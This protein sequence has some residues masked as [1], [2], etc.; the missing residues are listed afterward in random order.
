MCVGT[1]F[2]RSRPGHSHNMSP[3]LPC[4]F[5]WLLSFGVSLR[6]GLSAH[7]APALATRPVSAFIPGV[8]YRVDKNVHSTVNT[9]G[10]KKDRA[11]TRSCTMIKFR[12]GIFQV[13][14]FKKSRVRCPIACA[15]YSRQFVILKLKKL[16]PIKQQLLNI[17]YF[18]HC[19]TFSYK[20]KKHIIII[21]ICIAT[22]R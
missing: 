7:T 19:R 2:L 14:L 20:Y 15:A 10:R 4:L 13:V 6:A 12:L 1:G 8:G 5:G 22:I 17:Y 16:T 18:F 9:H 3:A 21:I 11:C